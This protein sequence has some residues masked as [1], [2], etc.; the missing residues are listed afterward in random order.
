M[1]TFGFG[2]TDEWGGSHWGAVQLQ[3]NSRFPGRHCKAHCTHKDGENM[4]WIGSLFFLHIMT[5]MDNSTYRKHWPRGPMLWKSSFESSCSP[6]KLVILQEVIL[7]L[8]RGSDFSPQFQLLPKHVKIDGRNWSN[9]FIGVPEICVSVFS[10]SSTEGWDT[11][12]K[13]GENCFFLL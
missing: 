7:S 10:L 8:Q 12:L 4:T 11:K 1:V 2:Q 5:N 6:W 3:P 13:K 9:L